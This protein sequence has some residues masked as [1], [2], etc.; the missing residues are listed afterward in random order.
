MMACFISNKKIITAPEGTVII[1]LGGEQGGLSRCCRTYRLAA[2]R[3]H[4]GENSPPDCFLPKAIRL[5]PSLFESLAFNTTKNKKQHLTV[6]PFSWYE[7]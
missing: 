2:A 5:S 1:F 3:C 7:C 4:V 6:L